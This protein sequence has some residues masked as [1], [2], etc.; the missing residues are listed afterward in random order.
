MTPPEMKAAEVD[1]K[2]E[3]IRKH[4]ER[5]PEC[6]GCGDR[7]WPIKTGDSWCL[8]CNLLH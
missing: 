7:F 3:L 5:Y 8:R 4:A 1:R 2:L 6:R